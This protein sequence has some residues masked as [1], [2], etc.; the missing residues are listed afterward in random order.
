MR[1][2]FEFMRTAYGVNNNFEEL[3]NTVSTNSEI[4]WNALART[5]L[6]SDKTE[7]QSSNAENVIASIY[8]DSKQTIQPEISVCNVT[9]P[10]LGCSEETTERNKQN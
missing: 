10:L 7:S 1:S 8:L 5:D 9:K 4:D 2:F 6:N 3:V